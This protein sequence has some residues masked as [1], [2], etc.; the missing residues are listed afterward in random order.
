MTRN[1]Q[2][3]EHSHSNYLAVKSKD[4][5]AKA[6]DFK[7]KSKVFMAKSK[8]FTAK[9]KDFTAKSKDFMT[10]SK[11]FTALS[12]DIKPKFSVK[13][14]ESLYQNWTRKPKAV[15]RHGCGV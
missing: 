11:D 6:K 1:T 7:A 15:K 10:K 9:A 13:K 5:T 14:L 3:I 8:D 12:Y 4:F 2:F